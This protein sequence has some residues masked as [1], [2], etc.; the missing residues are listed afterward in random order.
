[1]SL[2][3]S[4][5]CYWWEQTP[6]NSQSWHP[7]KYML[8]SRK[9][10][11]TRRFSCFS[12]YFCLLGTLCSHVFLLPSPNLTELGLTPPPCKTHTGQHTIVASHGHQVPDSLGRLTG[13][14]SLRL[15]ENP[16]LRGPIP[17][18]LAAR[19]DCAVRADELVFEDTEATMLGSK[20]DEWFL[21]PR[22]ASKTTHN[23][24]HTRD[25]LLYRKIGD[26]SSWTVLR[27]LQSRRRD[28]CLLSN[29]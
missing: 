5:C 11:A 12:S 9:L 24:Y 3:C 23:L 25:R 2:S 27:R 6:A 8:T 14:R 15:E 18:P 21:M 17:G 7:E 13:L 4:I 1:M 19:P 10:A 22:K 28:T 29:Q 16:S 20:L 26:V